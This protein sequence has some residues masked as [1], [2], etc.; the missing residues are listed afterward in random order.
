MRNRCKSWSVAGPP[1]GLMDIEQDDERVERLHATVT[2]E[3]A[4]RRFDQVLAELFSDYSRTRLSEWVKSGD[5]R[6]DGEQVR[7]REA[8]RVG[9]Q[10]TVE[11][12][13]NTRLNSSH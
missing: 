12:R 1:R 2:Q 9:Q 13:K 7:P 8:V 3:Q 6:L 5:A 10:I 4:G 11:D